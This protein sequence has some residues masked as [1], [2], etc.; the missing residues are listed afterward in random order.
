MGK[1]TGIA[2][3]LLGHEARR[4]DQVARTQCGHQPRRPEL[5]RAGLRATLAEW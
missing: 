4:F 2:N 5:Q 3:I 1:V